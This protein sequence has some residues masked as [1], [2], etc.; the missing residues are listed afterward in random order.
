LQTGKKVYVLTVLEVLEKHKGNGYSLEMLN[1]LHIQYKCP[2]AP[3]NVHNIAYWDHVFSK[4]GDD[5][6]LHASLSNH[7][8]D[9]E[10]QH[11]KKHK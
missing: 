11:W 1:Y 2:I 10:R 6:F 5:S 7:E 3:A 9:V 8:F 4:Y